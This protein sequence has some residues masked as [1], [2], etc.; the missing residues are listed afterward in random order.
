[1][2]SNQIIIIQQFQSRNFVGQLVS[3]LGI[4]IPEANTPPPPPPLQNYYYELY[5][6][7]TPP[8][9]QSIKTIDCEVTQRDRSKQENDDP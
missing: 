9:N 2:S 3:K 6:L 5:H 8:I 1:M 7:K 4:C